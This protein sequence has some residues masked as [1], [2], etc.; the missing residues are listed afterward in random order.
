M[1]KI[2][3]V[4]GSGFIGTSLCRRV[5]HSSQQ[6]V[7]IDRVVSDSFPS[8]TL[9]ADVRNHDSLLGVV[10][11]FSILINLAAEHRDDV[12]PIDLYYDV[13][14]TGARNVCSV[15]RLKNINTIIF[16]STVA[17]YGL[18]PTATTEFGQISPFNDYGRSKF[19]AEKIYKIWQAEVPDKRT[20][21]IVR[22]TVVFGEK[23]RGNVYNL[24]DHIASGKFV[25]VGDG[26][27]KK[28]MAYVENVSSFL[29]FSTTSFK[30][31]LH[32]YNYI[33]KP[34]YNMNSL[35]IMVNRILGKKDKVGFRIPYVLGF[36]IGK[37][38]DLLSALFRKKLVISSVRVKKF[39]SNSVYESSI[40]QTAFVPQ[41]QLAV[42]LERT[43]R[44]EFIES[45][46]NDRVFYTE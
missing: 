3:I 32:I 35:V 6:F 44:Y 22:P 43:I 40:S 42:A 8:H 15:A 34:D 45:H 19:E 10:P 21:V 38:F 26:L 33:D 13:N 37:L 31:G 20:L 18:T 14:V 41:V 27:N 36:F 16:T 4:G 28:S 17:V 12:R 1:K 39:C 2:C 25:M 24:L 5:E 23:N 9:Q 7:I 11:E 46:E 30:P 29:Q